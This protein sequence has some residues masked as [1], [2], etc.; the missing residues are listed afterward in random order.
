MIFG[1]RTKFG[2]GKT[3]AFCLIYDSL[4]SLQKFEPKYRLIRAGKVEAPKIKKTRRTKKEE[5]NKLKK[6]RG[7]EK[8][9][10]KK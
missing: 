5:K 4:D 10:G 8:T 3:H 6:L 7:T 2:G 1:S 9:K